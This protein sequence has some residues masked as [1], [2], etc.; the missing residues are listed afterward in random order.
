MT[1]KQLVAKA[2]LFPLA[3]S[4][5]VVAIALAGWTYW[6]TTGALVDAQEAFDKATQQNDLISKNSAASELLAEQLA[7]LT[8]DATKLDAGL[9]NPIEDISNQQYFYDLEQAAGVEQISDPVHTETSRTKE[10]GNPSVASFSLSVAGH[11]DNILAFL[12]ALQ[13][14]PHPLRVNLMQITKSAQLRSQGGDTSRLNLNLAVE[15]LGK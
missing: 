14:G 4:L 2:K 11:W 8:A 6:R 9:I 13:T 7:E 5:I 10:P 1:S 3:I 15:L 12:H